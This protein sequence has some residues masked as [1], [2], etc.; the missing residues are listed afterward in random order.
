VHATTTWQ[1]EVDRLMLQQTTVLDYKKRKQIY[2]RV[3]ELVAEHVP[4]ICLV[5]PNV[6][7]GAKDSI[8]GI[9]PS[10]MRRHLL[11]NADQLF[12]RPQGATKDTKA[13]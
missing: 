1:S 7:V 3:Q 13:F 2:D 4:V 8:G 12:L 9:R 10:V 5:S 6:L 11:W